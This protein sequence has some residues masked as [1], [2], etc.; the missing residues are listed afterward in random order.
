QMLADSTGLSVALPAAPEPVLLGAAMLG[1]VA[2]GV[3][4]DA[5]SAMAAMSGSARLFVPASGDLAALH[6]RRYAG[7]IAL[8]QAAREIRTLIAAP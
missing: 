4:G 6:V 7:F 2:S 1:A 8:Q 3:H 5:G